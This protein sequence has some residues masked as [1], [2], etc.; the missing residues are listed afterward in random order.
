VVVRWHIQRG[1]IVFP[2]TLTAPR[3]RENLEVFDFDLAEADMHAISSLDRG[4]AGREGPHPD[5]CDWTPD[6]QWWADLG[7][8]EPA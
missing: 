2:K 1:D 7:V 4:E 8:P 3:M 6:S 5:T